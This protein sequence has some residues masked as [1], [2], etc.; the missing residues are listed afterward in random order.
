MG[1]RFGDWKANVNP[2]VVHERQSI[3][4]ATTDESP[5]TAAMS[6]RMLETLPNQ[7]RI[8][9]A[10]QRALSRS[11]AAPASNAASGRF[12][13]LWAGLRWTLADEPPV[14]AVGFELENEPSGLLWTIYRR[15]GIQKVRGSNPLG[16]TNV[17][18]Q[19]IVHACGKTSCVSHRPLRAW[20]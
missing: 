18:S 2:V 6:L 11:A 20:P 15:H 8:W 17:L 12:D 4:T 5:H 14:I 16:S 3:A 19:D 1:P 9:H 10:S 7:R 13:S